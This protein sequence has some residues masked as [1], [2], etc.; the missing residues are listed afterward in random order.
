MLDLAGST[1]LADVE[2]VLIGEFCRQFGFV[3]VPTA[4]VLPELP[5]RTATQA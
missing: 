4:P 5:V 2:D 1:R 3:A